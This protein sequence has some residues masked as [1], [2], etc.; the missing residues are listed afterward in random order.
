[1]GR[2]VRYNSSFQPDQFDEAADK[3]RPDKAK[4]ARYA[5]VRL[6]RY[7]TGRL[8]FP[9]QTVYRSVSCEVDVGLLATDH[10]KLLHS[11]STRLIRYVPY[12]RNLNAD[13]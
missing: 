13:L 9:D 11:T 4:Q 7:V 3:T 8:D 2:P 1:M 10:A 12:V 5:A 6:L